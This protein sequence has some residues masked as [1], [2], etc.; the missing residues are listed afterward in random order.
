MMGYM[1]VYFMT[2]NWAQICSELFVVI[3]RAISNEVVKLA[4]FKG[5]SPKDVVGLFIY[6]FILYMGT[7]GW[8]T[9]ECT[10]MSKGHDV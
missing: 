10:R 2:S 6:F 8:V 7:L 4:V 9:V 3:Q 5:L 1:A